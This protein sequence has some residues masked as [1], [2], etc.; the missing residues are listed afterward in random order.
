MAYITIREATER[1]RVPYS[2]VY[3][4]ATT[5]KVASKT[6]VIDLMFVRHGK[7][8]HQPRPMV[9]VDED[10]AMLLAA[11]VLPQRT[12]SKEWILSMLVRGKTQRHIAGVCHI[13]VH[14]LKRRMDNLGIKSRTRKEASLLR[15]KPRYYSQERREEGRRRKT[16]FWEAFNWVND[17]TEMPTEDDMKEHYNGRFRAVDIY[18]MI[19]T[20]PFRELPSLGVTVTM[21]T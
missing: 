6:E 13:N 3:R 4:W 10:G 15:P 14:T 11:E 5:K 12:P 20:R 7:T 17:L 21:K 9:L 16:A 19:E 2:R 8:V 1:F 18:G